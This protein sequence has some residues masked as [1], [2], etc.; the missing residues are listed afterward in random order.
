MNIDYFEFGEKGK[1]IVFLHGWQQDKKSFSPLA[2]FL[3]KKNH[4]LMPDLPGFGKS[5]APPDSFN[6]FDYAREITNWIKSKKLKNI[7][8]VGHSF[9]GKIASLIAANTPDLVDKLILIASSGIPEKKFYYPY[10]KWLPKKIRTLF[11]PMLQSQ[12]YKNAGRLISIFKN[13]VQEDIRDSFIKI[14]CPTLIIWGRQDRQLPLSMGKSING[15][16]KNSQL[17]IVDSDHFPFFEQPEKIAEDIINF[18][19]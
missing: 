5:E 18:I 13:V 6:S 1:P 16:I 9:G 3:F 11:S 8:L 4:L 10:L 17:K 15:L 14:E 19:K 2:P 7:V 12:D